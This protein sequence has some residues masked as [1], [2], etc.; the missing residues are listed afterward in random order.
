MAAVPPT[1][2]FLELLNEDCH[3]DL[4]TDDGQVQAL[5]QRYVVKFRKGWTAEA[6]AERRELLAGPLWIRANHEKFGE[7]FSRMS[8]AQQQI[9]TTALI[10]DKDKVAQIHTLRILV[11]RR[12]LARCF[13]GD[14]VDTHKKRSADTPDP[15]TGG[16]IVKS[17]GAPKRPKTNSAPTPT[18][19]TDS[20]PSDGEEAIIADPPLASMPDKIINT[21]QFRTLYEAVCVLQ[22]LSTPDLDSE[23]SLEPKYGHSSSGASPGPQRSIQR[24]TRCCAKR[25]RRGAARTRQTRPGCT[26]HAYPSAE[27]LRLK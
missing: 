7:S 27:I 19:S 8:G 25:P 26:E 3:Y 5:L 12:I 9:I 15:N 24:T 2:T 11:V 1:R 20:P 16:Q 6:T 10:L 22:W 21:D 18:A 14:T 17:G 13:P 23:C 4:P